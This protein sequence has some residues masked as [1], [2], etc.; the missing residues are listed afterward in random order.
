MESQEWL[1][2]MLSE[3]NEFCS[4]MITNTS[5]P[6]FVD[7]A[8]HSSPG[9][10][11]S[12]RLFWPLKCVIRGFLWGDKAINVPSNTTEYYFNWR[13]INI[14]VNDYSSFRHRKSFDLWNVK[15][16]NRSDNRSETGA[17]INQL[18]KW[19]ALFRR[20]IDH[21]GSRFV[22]QSK[23]RSNSFGIFNLKGWLVC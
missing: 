16:R 6:S 4:E 22:N 23:T 15:G 19:S 17:E 1:R 18:V 10:S 2:Q 20:L 3:I 8:F 11:F 5:Q 9:L 12:L 14:G 7:F 21:V 13:R